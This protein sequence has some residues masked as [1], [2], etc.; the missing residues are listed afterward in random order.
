MILK[1]V[2]MTYKKL[3]IKETLSHINYNIIKKHSLNIFPNPLALPSPFI[4]I[5]K[6]NLRKKY[7]YKKATLVNRV[8]INC[9]G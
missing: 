1:A 3:I 9:N 6:N 7:V 4:E 8:K 5:M 2:S